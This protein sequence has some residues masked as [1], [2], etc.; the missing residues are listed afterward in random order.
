MS[1]TIRDSFLADAAKWFDGLPHQVTAWNWLQDQLSEATLNDFAQRFSPTAVA[2]IKTGNPFVDEQIR[3]L[4]GYCAP[5]ARPN[6]DVTTS[7]YSQR[8]NYTMPHRTCNSSSNAM[9]LDWLRRSVGRPALGGDNDYLKT[10]LAI[11]DTIYHENQTAALNKYGFRTAWRTDS[12]RANVDALLDAGFPVVVN[13]LHR[14]S[15]TNPTGGHVIMLCGRRKSEGTYI[16]H[17]PYGTLGSNYR[18]TNGKHAPISLRSFQARWQGGY[19][20]LAQ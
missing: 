19:R 18:D 7:Y 16:S 11:G 2:E 12:N 3:L 17:D 8:D 1:N 13:I 20:I 15:I 10:L 6:L 4:A 9:Y 14:G 5:G